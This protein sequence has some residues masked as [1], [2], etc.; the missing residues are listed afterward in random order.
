MKV[1]VFDITKLATKECWKE[2]VPDRFRCRQFFNAIHKSYSLIV[3]ERDSL[4]TPLI[5]FL[6]SKGAVETVVSKVR[7]PDGTDVDNISFGKRF[8]IVNDSKLCEYIVYIDN[9]MR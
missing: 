8:M 7:F 6:L 2:R 3:V 4:S 1:I 9:L 5:K